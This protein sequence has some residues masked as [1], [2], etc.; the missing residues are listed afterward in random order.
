M[1]LSHSFL[2]LLFFVSGCSKKK[3]HSEQTILP[4]VIDRNA[5]ITPSPYAS[6]QAATQA[7]EVATVTQTSQQERVATTQELFQE[8]EARFDDLYI[9]LG[10]V[11]TVCHRHEE[12]FFLEG[13]VSESCVEGMQRCQYAMERFGWE[14]GLSMAVEPL[15]TVYTKPGRSCAY[16]LTAAKASWFSKN[17]GSVLRLWFSAI[18]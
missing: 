4:A 16:Q 14:R 15:L 5:L 2:L 12:G 10:F 18:V 17:N 11:P 8:I 13:T 3:K 1:K 7:E 9:P 6:S